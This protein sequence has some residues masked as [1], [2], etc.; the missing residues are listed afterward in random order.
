VIKILFFGRLEDIA[1]LE[2]CPVEYS[3]QVSTADQLKQKLAKDN[4]DLGDALS[5]PQIMVAINQSIVAWNSPIKDGDEVAFLP[6]VTG[7]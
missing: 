6:P 3:E 5:Q 4:A 7:G 1:G 2:S